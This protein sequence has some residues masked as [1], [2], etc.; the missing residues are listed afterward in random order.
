MFGVSTVE[1]Q[2]KLNP[3]QQYVLMMLS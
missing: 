3:K 2:V 1:P